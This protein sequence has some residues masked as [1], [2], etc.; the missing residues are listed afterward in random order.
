MSGNNHGYTTLSDLVKG[1]KLTRMQL[2]RY[3]I[4]IINIVHS[5]AARTDHRQG[6]SVGRW[7][8]LILLPDALEVHVN[9]ALGER[10]HNTHPVSGDSGEDTQ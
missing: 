8:W 3:T 5:D 7:R 9:T 2:K 1:L 4:V 6:D 10:R